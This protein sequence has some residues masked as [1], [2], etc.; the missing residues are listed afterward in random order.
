MGSLFAEGVNWFVK[1]ME[2][3]CS[4]S[5]YVEGSHK[6][7]Q[8]GKATKLSIKSNSVDIKVLF[9]ED[10]SSYSVVSHVNVPADAV[11]VIVATTNS[12]A[13][14]TIDEETEKLKSLN[15]AVIFR[16][17]SAIE[18]LSIESKTGDIVLNNCRAKEVS[19]IS[20]A[21]DIMVSDHI[22][23]CPTEAIAENGDV[24]RVNFASK[25]S[26]NKMVCKTTDG[27]IVLSSR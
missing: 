5:D 18:T 10:N 16:V 3:S 25:P 9:I 7:L 19:I 1:M 22:V 8:I 20:A 26:E 4:A 2:K 23:P 17:N 15:A 24:T 14:I 12:S 21:G 27:D 13:E 11:K 6:A